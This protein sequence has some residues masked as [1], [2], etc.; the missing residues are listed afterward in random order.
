MKTSW[1]LCRICSSVTHEH[2]FVWSTDWLNVP[3]YMTF[4]LQSLYQSCGMMCTYFFH[5]FT[6]NYRHRHEYFA[7]CCITP[8]LHPLSI[9]HRHDGECKT[10]F[11]EPADIDE[12]QEWTWHV[13]DSVVSGRL[14]EWPLSLFSPEWRVGIP[15][16][17]VDV[18]LGS[19][20][21][22]CVWI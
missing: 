22:C 7:N 12:E 16:F 4:I 8:C 18:T 17:D 3:S 21:S 19:D 15:G 1:G 11:V 2:C 9:R 14:K 5:V 10:G 6:L 13:F 20:I